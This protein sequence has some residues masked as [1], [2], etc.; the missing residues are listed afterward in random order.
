MQRLILYR[1]YKGH[2]RLKLVSEILVP[3]PGPTLWVE[4]LKVREQI[5]DK[6]GQQPCSYES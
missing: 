2:E 6:A 3:T 4:D 1:T 5:T